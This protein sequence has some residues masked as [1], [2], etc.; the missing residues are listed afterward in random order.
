MH[1]SL[2]LRLLGDVSG[3]M[4]WR[5]VGGLLNA[6][7]LGLFVLNTPVGIIREWRLQA[8]VTV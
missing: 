3:A 7:A 5:T 6:F 2:A 4:A 8:K 1:F